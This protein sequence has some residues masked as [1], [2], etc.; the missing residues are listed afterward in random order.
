MVW[1]PASGPW[2]ARVDA[3]LW[4]CEAASHFFTQKEASLPSSLLLKGVLRSSVYGSALRNNHHHL[5]LQDSKRTYS[6]AKCSPCI[7]L[8]SVKND[9]VSTSSSQFFELARKK[10]LSPHFHATEGRL[11]GGTFERATFTRK[12]PFEGRDLSPGLFHSG[13]GLSQFQ[14]ATQQKSAHDSQKHAYDPEFLLHNLKKVC[15]DAY[16]SG[17]RTLETTQLAPLI[18]YSGPLLAIIAF[19]LISGVIVG[20]WLGRTSTQ[21]VQLSNAGNSQVVTSSEPKAP[22]VYRLGLESWLV[23]LLQPLIDNLQKPDYV[24]RVQ[25]KRFDLGDE[26]I[27]V[28]SVERRTSRRVN[29]LQYHIGLRYT[30]GARMLLLLKLRAGFIPIT[31]PV[32]VRGL[33]VDGELWVKLRLVPTEPWVGT[34]TW[35]F[36]SLPKIKLDLSPFRLF[37]LMAIPFLSIFLTKLLTEDLP[38]L[39][40]RPN[41]NVI[42]FL[43]GKAVGPVPKDFKGSTTERNKDFSGELS[44]TLVNARKLR[45]APFGKSD[46]YVILILGDQVIRS[47]KNSQTSVIG[48]PGGPIWNQDFQLLVVDPKIQRLDVRVRDFLGLTAFT[49]GIGEV[50]LISLRDTVPV[51]KVVRLRGGWGPFQRRLAGEVLL[52]LTYTAYVDDEEED[53]KKDAPLPSPRNLVSVAE[54]TT[55][56]LPLVKEVIDK[57][58]ETVRVENPVVSQAVTSLLNVEASNGEPSNNNELLE[59]EDLEIENNNGVTTEAAGKGKIKEVAPAIAEDAENFSGRTV[60]LWLGVVTLLSI[61]MAISHF[62]SFMNP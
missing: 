6:A 61:L 31:I 8:A 53:I 46:P 27:S 3:G 29:D 41:K 30:G 39:F 36:V 22:T 44:V 60:L 20:R 16:Q 51:D 57:V 9:D 50:D 25:I 35:A 37:N 28:R 62:S 52:R 19:A 54:G 32:G 17:V 40:V 38:R 48:L 4:E 15:K 43:Q 45:Y 42:D 33:D 2:S 11:P 34:A 56:A 5:P 24:S 14:A 7:L 23:S 21:G 47:K 49:V 13:R 12:Y 1:Q 55:D 26:P 18:P 10:V 58:V 59:P